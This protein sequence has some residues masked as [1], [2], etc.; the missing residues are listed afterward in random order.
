MFLR[1][2]VLVVAAMTLVLLGGLVAA[3]V[4]R[5]RVPVQPPIV[6]SGADVGFQ[7]TARE[8]TTPIGNVVVQ[9]DGK[10][11]PIKFESGAVRLSTR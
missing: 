9:V 3:Q 1:L 10:W 2:R 7:I 11:V 8:G 6:L 5:E 4:L